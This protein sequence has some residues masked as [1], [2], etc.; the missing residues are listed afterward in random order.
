MIMKNEIRPMS[1]RTSEDKESGDLHCSVLSMTKIGIVPWQ[2]ASY[3]LNWRPSG[4]DPV[5]SFHVG[6]T[7]HRNGISD[8]TFAELLTQAFKLMPENI[9]NRFEL[10]PDSLHLNNNGSP[11]FLVRKIEVV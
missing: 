8:E 11:A 9:R 3:C 6:L 2:S 10:V 7:T 1:N 5:T 4:S